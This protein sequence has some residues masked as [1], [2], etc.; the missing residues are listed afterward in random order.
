MDIKYLDIKILDM[1]Q[2]MP[3]WGTAAATALAPLAW[4]TTY[5]TVTELLPAGRP[6]LVAA[7]RV[8]PAGVALVL[9]GLVRHRWWPARDQVPALLGL[10]LCNFGLFFPLLI[11]AVYRLPG[12]VAAAVGGIQPLLVSLLTALAGGG[13]PRRIDVA[14]GIVAAAGVALV[15]VRPGAGIDPVGVLAALGAN[16]SFAIG[17]VA[18][19]RIAP[20][21]HRLAATGWQLL[22]A[23]VAL[24]PLA[25]VV[26]GAPPP[27]DLRALGGFA[28]LSLAATGVAFAL[29]FRG[30]TRLPS[31]APP[32]LGLLAPLTGATAG[33][34]LLGE[35]LSGPQ[36]L[37]F[38]LTIAAVTHGARLRP[39]DPDAPPST[40]Q[41]LRHRLQPAGGEG[42]PGPL[43]ALLTHQQA[44]GDQLGEVVAGG[45]LRASEHLRQVAGADLT[46]AGG[47]DDGQDLQP[48][49]IREHLQRGREGLRGRAINR[50]AH[51]RTAGRRG[52]VDE[53]EAGHTSILTHIDTTANVSTIIDSIAIDTNRRTPIMR[54]QLALN[55]D[56]LDRAVDFYSR[57]FDTE[58]ARRRPG[59]ANF[60]IAEPPLKLVLFE[61]AGT[62]GTINHLGV[63]TETVEEVHDAADRLVAS[64]LTTTGVADTE[65]CYAQ[66]TETWLSGPDGTRWEWYVRTGDAETLENVVVTEGGATCCAP[67][68]EGQAPTEPA[69]C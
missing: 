7:L 36:V 4:G 14:V 41:G 26:E 9:V 56:D 5:V 43:A 30:I 59:Y 64:G 44:L 34:L 22:A 19:R 52:V 27:L 47:G 67:T 6:L 57:M 2:T 13:R 63:E 10:A 61:G 29:W 48:G 69:C 18:T 40:H 54:L 16:V 20:P 42:E 31:A 33:W 38:A 50:L 28:Y 66:K 21:P 1:K 8:A 17:V 39:A 53:G 35:D 65:C 23:A 15:V 51:R 55:V 32:L 49:R 60:A 58:P 12:G 3:A 68:A 45:G 24:V 37:G 46:T 11:V 25:L 62:T